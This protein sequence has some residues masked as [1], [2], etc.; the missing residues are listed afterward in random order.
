VPLIALDRPFYPGTESAKKGGVGKP[1]SLLREGMAR[2]G[3]VAIVSW[4]AHQTEH[5]GMMVP[6]KNGLLIKGL[7]FY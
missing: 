1:Y 4:I 6:Y 3:K 5:L 2:S 7:L